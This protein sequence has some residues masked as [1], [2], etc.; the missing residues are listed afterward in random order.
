MLMSFKKILLTCLLI[1]AGLSAFAQ[2]DTIPLTKLILKTEQFTQNYPSEKVYVHFDKPYYAVGD[3][4]WL[5]TY[6]TLEQ[7]QLSAISK[8]VYV[9]LINSRDS[10]VS[11]LRI[12]LVNGTGNSSIVLPQLTFIE[13]NYHV[14]A[15]TNW[16]RNFDPA[17][18]FTKNITI[19]NTAD[20]INPINTHISFVNSVSNLTEKI[21]A[22]IAYK[23]QDGVA[24]IN[25]RVSWKVQ[26]DDETIDKGK[27][28]TDQN[29]ILDISFS[30]T[31]P[32]IFA[33][34]DLT[35]EIELNY[36]KTIT[37]TFSLKTAS[38][39]KDVQ[40]FPEGGNMLAG[41]RS[42]IAFKAINSNGLGVDVKGNVTDDANK[43]VA[44]FTSQHSGMG[45]FTFQP[46]TG[47]SYK[48]NITF[49]DGTQSSY[50]LPR[51]LD[52]GIDLT[53]YNT[54]PD[55]LI[56]KLASN[57]AFLQKFANTRF[58]LVAQ[59]S[60]HIYYAAQTSLQSLVYT[61]AIPKS[62]FPTGI[63][64]IS[65]LTSE[66]DPISERIVFI[67]HND[68]LNVSLTTNRP[69]YSIRQKVLMNLSV[70]NKDV[71]D[72]GTF[73]LSVTDETKIPF[74]E[75]DET[76]ILS[77]LLLSSDIKGYI[78]KP[79]YYFNHVDAT[80]TADLDLLMLTQGY[81]KFT[82]SDII[83]DKNPQIYFLPEHGINISGTLRTNT[84][85]PVSKANIH[86][87]IP[88]KIAAADA[89][90]DNMGNY[91]FINVDF[92]DSSKI[93]LSARNNAGSKYLVITANGETIPALAKNINSPDNITNI[94]ST[95]ATYLQNTKRQY[96]GTQLLKEVVIKAKS[97]VKKPSHIDYPALTGLSVEPD[98]LIKGTQFEGCNFLLDCLRG[99]AFGFTYDDTKGE[100]YLTRDYNQGNKN[101]P[102]AIY[103]NGLSVESSYI[104]SIDPKMVE[105]V[106]IFLDDGVSNINKT[107]QTKGVM[108]ING[109]KLDKGEKI[110]LAQ[111]KEMLPQNDVI[112][113]TP[114]GYARKKEFYEPKY[115]TVKPKL[116]INDL[117]TTIYWNPKIV[118]D[119]NGKAS[120]EFFNA[121]GKGSYR[122]VLEGIDADGNLARYIYHYKVE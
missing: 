81:R 108:V 33:G 14:R 13:G 48:A 67:Q 80:R 97:E 22:R 58:Y 113:I 96:A 105:S 40:F 28:M 69:V 101:T 30:S 65:L 50:D 103:Y 118:T 38:K 15:Y 5:K 23:D 107:T 82:Y 18:F 10:I 78:E 106:E 120:F 114:M 91:A 17:Y 98:H 87:I 90:T 99:A 77:S 42:K 68:L 56:I 47:K 70:K 72:V 21:N 45:V 92:Q 84:G 27:G 63:L 71:P 16:M 55:T 121:D 29:G 8:I 86:M 1:T 32:G 52:E 26:A 61:A 89:T 111:L 41:M 79:N 54:N 94:D 95:L 20:K 117:R 100:F 73:S 59:S 109:K 12:P 3:T 110:S 9:D 49:P 104:Q 83:A 7:H 102:V 31:K 57:P 85:I 19:G 116:D 115:F 93:T 6:V 66:G 36:K 43:E 25:R 2:D 60:G 122:A 4:I 74:N 64:Q 112:T 88:D 39:P 53:A 11:S 44:Q 76:T 46:E 34:A 24:Y 37:N 75:D 119:A 51:V 62:K 35:T